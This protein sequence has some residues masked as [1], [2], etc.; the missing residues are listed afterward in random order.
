MLSLE[1]PHP[2][3]VRAQ[4]ALARTGYRVSSHNCLAEKSTWSDLQ[5]CLGLGY[6]G[7]LV[8]KNTPAESAVLVSVLFALPFVDTSWR[9]D[10]HVVDIEDLPFVT[11]TIV[12]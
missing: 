5:I 12:T 6:S 4:R 2:S 3:A 1:L 10:L 8:E 9:L 7:T 11:Q